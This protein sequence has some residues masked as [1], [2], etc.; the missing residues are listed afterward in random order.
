[1]QNGGDARSDFLPI[2]ARRFE[3]TSQRCGASI[4]PIRVVV[5]A[6]QF[7]GEIGHFAFVVGRNDIVDLENHQ[8]HDADAKH[9]RARTVA[10]QGAH[11]R[12]S[13]RKDAMQ[14]RDDRH[15]FHRRSK[16]TLHGIVTI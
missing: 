12:A 7:F 9:Q 3:Q 11:R 5:A 15:R 10:S 1:M 6:L 2:A 16:K 13:D 14:A 8:R 4:N